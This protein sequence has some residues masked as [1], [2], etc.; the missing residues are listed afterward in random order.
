VPTIITSIEETRTNDGDTSTVRL[1]VTGVAAGDAGDCK[2]I[3]A[4]DGYTLGA[5][6]SGGGVT[7]ITLANLSYS[8]VED[9]G[10]TIWQA[11][12]S[13]S[14]DDESESPATYSKIESSTKA[15]V[16]D[17]WRIGA[18][19]D[20]INNPGATYDIG[21][22]GVDARGVPVS[23]LVVQQ[24]LTYTVQHNF[25]NSDQATVNAMIGT[26]NSALFL[27]GNAGY[28]LFTGVRRSRIAVNLYEVTYTFVWDA[29]AHL[30]Q[31]PDRDADGEPIIAIGGAYDKKAK[32][33]YARQ[34][35][36]TLSNFSSLP[37][38]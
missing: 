37:G 13:Y 15:E 33:V 3:L 31:I 6:Y 1:L 30:R 2:D 9:S 34:P 14:S 35:F 23:A 12:A 11:T 7:G 28:V 26:R 19:A 16:V 10:G 8:P 4:T 21:G 38:I 27:G 5:A 18:T 36:P 32:F 29:A 24:E 22:T 25:T 20:N 17:V